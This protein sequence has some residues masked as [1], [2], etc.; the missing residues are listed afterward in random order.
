LSV[1][2]GPNDLVLC[3]GT[4]PRETPFVLRL[5]AAVAAGCS[6]I[7]LWG[8]DYRAARDEG[9][10]DADLVAMI[11]DRGLS[12]A[13]L[14]PAWWW[15]P[16]AEAFSIPDELDPVEVF[17]YDEAELFRIADLVG[18]RSL[19]AAD[20]LGGR[21]GV[22]E[23]AAAFAA[24]C[25]RAAEH[26]LLVHLEWL[27]WSRVPDLATAWEIVRSADR[28]NGG[29]NVDMWHCARTGTTSAELL[30]LPGD[31]VLAIQLDDGP[32]RAEDDLVEA[33]LHHRMLPGGGDFDLVGYLSALRTI[34]AV[35]PVGI[36][37]F[38]DALHA[39]GPRDAARRAA[40]ATRHVLSQVDAVTQAR[41]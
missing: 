40:D 34:G 8:R 13:E 32:A 23:G 27:A 29:L 14:D 11:A 7:S 10:S 39:L 17:R 24:L 3:S 31:R 19:N 38:S 25:D 18:A 36:E 35:A 6:A 9:H 2:L 28:P 1:G 4:L 16:G 33:T 30:G 20:V 15:T 22:D 41:G 5:E 26:G 21:W 37:V 12:V